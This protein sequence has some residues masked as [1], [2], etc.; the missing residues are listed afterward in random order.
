MGIAA[1][2]SMGCETDIGRIES[3]SLAGAESVKK[4]HDSYE[5]YSF[6]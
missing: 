3:P 1:N 6:D 4:I 2:E 5:I